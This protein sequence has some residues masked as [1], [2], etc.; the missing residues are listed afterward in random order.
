MHGKVGRQIVGA[1]ILYG[2]QL[3]TFTQFLFSDFYQGIT[4]SL[5]IKIAGIGVLGIDK[6]QERDFT[7]RQ[8]IVKLHL[9]RV[10][11]RFPDIEETIPKIQGLVDSRIRVFI[12]VKI[13]PNDIV[14]RRR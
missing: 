13:V 11:V 14:V 9:L 4:T 5:P 10:P 1:C 3:G 8:L 7:E 6:T 12:D 2:V